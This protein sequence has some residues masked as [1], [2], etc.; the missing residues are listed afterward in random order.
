MCENVWIYMQR[1]HN[2]CNHG[3]Q[4][5]CSPLGPYLRAKN[6]GG[7]TVEGMEGW[8]KKGGVIDMNLIKQETDLINL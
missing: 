3:Y 2:D 5:V 1:G 4:V 7:E 8:K 6:R